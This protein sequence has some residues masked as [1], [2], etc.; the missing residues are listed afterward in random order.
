[1]PARTWLVAALLALTTA[2]IFSPVIGFDFV[3]YDDPVFVTKNVYVQRGLSREFFA[4]VSTAEV[5]GNWHPL[6]MLS[7]GIDWTLFGPAPG[8]HHATSLTLHALNT[9]LLFVLFERMTGCVWRSALVAALFGL[10]PLHVESVAWVSERKD[11][12]STCLWFLTTLA[13]VSYTRRPGGVRY[14]LV[15]VA[16]ALGLMAKPMLVTLPFTL[17]L[18]DYWPL[19]RLS[20]ARAVR[21][22]VLEKLPLVGLAAAAAAIT[23]AAQSRAGALRGLASHSFAVRVENAIVSY[24]SY[25]WMTVWPA[26]LGILYPHPGDALSLALVAGSAVLL[27]AVTAAVVA[28]RRSNPY[29]LVGWLWYVGTLVPVIGLVQAGEQAMADRFTYV[30]LVGIFLAVAW[31]LP[32]APLASPVLRVAIPVVFV[33]LVIRTRAQLETWRDSVTLY[34][35]ALALNERNPSVH[36]NLGAVL[37]DRGDA[38][39]ARPHLQA[40]IDQTDACPEGRQNLA[41]ILLAE[42]RPAEAITLLEQALALRP[43]LAD[44]HYNLGNAYVRLGRDADALEPFRTALR[45]NPD[46]F[47]AAFNLGNAL[48]RLGALPEAVQ[49]Y[50]QALRIKPDL[51][52]AHH[53]LATVYLRTNDFA[54][55]TRHY[56]EALRLDPSLDQARQGLET[57]Q[58]AM[59]R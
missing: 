33:A 29:L 57:A 1:V 5:A 25:L 39:G 7:H 50:E 8:G 49:A 3:N 38:A 18:L 4:W 6:T 11:V 48:Q 31:A 28:L 10:H 40:C 22:A 16:F 59:R 20:D 17:L 30:P 51:A 21:R 19:G 44:A 34:E 45:W 53:N 9:A 27:L 46:A 32:S 54:N 42:G 12:L 35:H 56:Q 2:V 23:I 47:M 36:A 43:D 55:A 24:A 15:L 26:C 13:W 14:L 52:G 58:Q 41:I 37:L